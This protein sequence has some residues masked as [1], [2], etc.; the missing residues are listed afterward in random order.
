VSPDGSVVV[1]GTVFSFGV[2]GKIV[3]VDAADGSILWSM[4]ISGPSAGIAGP[5][6]FSNDGETVYAPIT[7]IGGVNKL[8]AVSVQGTTGGPNL[9]VTGT[10]PG[11]V[12]MI[13]TG[14]TPNA[15]V[16]IYGSKSAGSTTIMNGG[17]AGTVL[18]L[19]KARL[20]AT[21]TADATGKATLNVRLNANRCGLLLQAVDLGDCATSNVANSP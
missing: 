6:S 7:E 4:A 3:A 17:C 2:N 5:V 1:F 10:C 11:T 19:K 16:Q 15:S 9:S 12:R 14:A 18:E 20:L 13:V 21:G 8:L